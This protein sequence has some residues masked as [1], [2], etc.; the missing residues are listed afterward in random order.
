M[1]LLGS[2]KAFG[3]CLGK[4]YVKGFELHTAGYWM[5]VGKGHVTGNAA[6][7]LYA[8]EKGHSKGYEKSFEVRFVCL[9]A[10]VEGRLKDLKGYA[11][12]NGY[13][14]EK[15]HGKGYAKS[16]EVRTVRY[17]TAFEKRAT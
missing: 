10:F 9:K 7:N 15:G 6:G 14:F 17:L 13:A 3:N 11:A 4:G 12:C 8:F 16:F 5:A 1:R 2:K